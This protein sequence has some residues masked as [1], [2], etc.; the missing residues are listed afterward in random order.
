MGIASSPWQLGNAN[1]EI[2]VSTSIIAQVPQ[3][4]CRYSSC[5]LA[6]LDVLIPPTKSRRLQLLFACS[7]N[8]PVHPRIPDNIS[9]L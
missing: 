5:T 7:N 6:V 4:L 2:N 9:N 3:F 1:N 8:P